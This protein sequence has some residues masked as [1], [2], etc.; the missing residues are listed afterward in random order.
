MVRM[1]EWKQIPIKK[2][3]T[4]EQRKRLR[5]LIR[6]VENPTSKDFLP[7]FIEWKEHLLKGEVMPE[8]LAYY[9]EHLVNQWGKDRVI[10]M[11]R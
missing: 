3:L 1:T 7:L 5:N 4:A 9:F 11:L 2:L 6:S 8:Y 10:E